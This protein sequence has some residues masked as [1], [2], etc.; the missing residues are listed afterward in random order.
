M[1]YGTSH[2]RNLNSE[3]DLPYSQPWPNRVEEVGFRNNFA[4]A[5]DQCQQDIEG[6]GAEKHGR[7]FAVSAL[8]YQLAPSLIE[9]KVLECVDGA[10]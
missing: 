9:A 5:F 4:A 8:P 7:S 6:S 10:D 3:I 2:S 1:I